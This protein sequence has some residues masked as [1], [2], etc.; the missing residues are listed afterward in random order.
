MPISLCQ[1]SLTHGVSTWNH[2]RTSKAQAQRFLGVG[3]AFLVIALTGQLAF[4][5]VGMAF[6]A[7]GVVFLAKSRKAG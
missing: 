2:A 1:A 6:I 5:G 7:L 3:I 4:L